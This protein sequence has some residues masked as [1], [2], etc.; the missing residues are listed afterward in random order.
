MK[1]LIKIGFLILTIF[2]L[3]PSQANAQKSTITD[4]LG[5][6]I[7]LAARQIM[8]AAATCALITLDNEGHSSIR[9]MDPFLPEDDFTVW[10]GTNP[11]SRK[12][13]QIK[14]IPGVSNAFCL[15]C[16]IYLL[17]SKT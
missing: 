14:R 8:T 6:K 9:M 15:I 2:F 1:T 10:L 3:I 12:V 13:A 17:L 7:K 16:L 4:S 5:V 11:N